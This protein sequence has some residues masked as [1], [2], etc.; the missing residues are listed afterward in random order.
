MITNNKELDR[1]IKSLR[2]DLSQKKIIKPQKEPFTHKLLR[3]LS[4]KR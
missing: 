1:I 2:K 3:E 4:K